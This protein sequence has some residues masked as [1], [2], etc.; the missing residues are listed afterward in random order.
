M[1]QGV[2]AS[3]DG[4]SLA[5]ANV[6]VAAAFNGMGKTTVARLMVNPAKGDLGKLEDR[7]A[8]LS[9][10]SQLPRALASLRLNVNVRRLCHAA[11]GSKSRLPELAK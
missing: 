8:G 3:K 6:H 10:A 5:E 9:F 7:V 1:L 4:S 11:A 2:K